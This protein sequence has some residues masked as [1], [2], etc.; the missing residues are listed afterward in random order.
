MK[1]AIERAKAH[2]MANRSTMNDKDLNEA[3]NALNVMIKE[4]WTQES[5]ESFTNGESVDVQVF[6]SLLKHYNIEITNSFNEWVQKD[7]VVVSKTGYDSYKIS[8]PKA[9]QLLSYVAQL[10]EIIDMP[11][12]IEAVIEANT[13]Q[14]VTTVPQVPY[15][16]VVRNGKI[17]ETK[18][19]E[20]KGD[21][22]RIDNIEYKGT[23]YVVEM[24]NGNLTRM[25]K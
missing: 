21:S 9:K 25:T 14:V 15:K 23:L 20:L 7:V 6:L 8:K 11:K 3:R 16:E 2:F 19:F 22:Y 12:L 5:I 10:T 1:A 4:M 17:V 18:R 24:K 13:A